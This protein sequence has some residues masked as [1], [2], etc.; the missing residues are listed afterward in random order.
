MVIPLTI[1]RARKMSKP[2]PW[3]NYNLYL[4]KPISEIR[5]E[6][7]IIILKESI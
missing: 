4:N 1:V 3:S 7:G 6:F 5:K 2:W